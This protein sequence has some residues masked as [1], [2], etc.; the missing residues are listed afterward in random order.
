[1]ST[2]STSI[3]LAILLLFHLVLASTAAILVLAPIPN[4]VPVV[5]PLVAMILIPPESALVVMHPHLE[6][7]PVYPDLITQLCNCGLVSLLNFPANVSSKLQHFLLL[8]M[9]EFSPEPLP[10]V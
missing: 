10:G 3:P 7:A 1:M 5:A 6:N 2:I 9:S 4:P 8:V